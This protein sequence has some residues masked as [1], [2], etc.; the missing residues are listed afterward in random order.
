MSDIYLQLF[1]ALERAGIRY[2]VIRDADR[3]G[4]P[5]H[6]GDTDILVDPV[7]IQRAARL[8][9][10]AGFIELREWGRSPHR[11]FV[12]Y[13]AERD[14]WIKC[15]VVTTIAY[16]RPVHNLATDL[17][18]DCL[19]HRRQSGKCAVPGA[20]EELL[21]LLLHCVIDKRA[22]HPRHAARLGQLRRDITRQEQLERLLA[23]YWPGLTWRD[24][25]ARIDAA[26]WAWLLGQ[27]PQVI[28]R[29]RQADYAGTVARAARDRLLRAL[30]RAIGLVRPAAPAVAL[31]APDGAGKSSL[32]EGFRARYF[33]P[34]HAVYMGF[35]RRGTEARPGRRVPGFGL[36]RSMATQWRRYLEARQRQAR[37]QL[38]L[39]DRY[40]YDALVPANGQG[41]LRR[42][43]RW[44]LAH[45]CP[46]PDLTVVLDAPGEV[47]FA[48]KGEHDAARLEA[49]RQSYLRLS[50]Q[51]ART[52][53]VDATRSPAEVRR[54]V[55]SLVC[56]E[57]RR[58]ARR[59]PAGAR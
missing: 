18:A 58:K 25:A 47:L 44:L 7:D 39:F 12:T 24:L 34:V 48:R 37:G 54:A 42:A 16:G 57:L 56:S 59:P 40:T 10:D 52:A 23:R 1:D 33:G 31:L 28:A 2:C 49:Q 38:V 30:R 14:R 19:A 15:D 22:F 32:V 50:T 41:L 51:R 36:V 20:E 46:P 8:L 53:V 3:I 17:A 45:A 21:T 43:R 4:S 55:A 9:A 35:H 29:L 27:R 13:D 6:D 5:D 26:D 11:F